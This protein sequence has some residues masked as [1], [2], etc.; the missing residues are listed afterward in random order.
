ML[1]LDTK[2]MS[3]VI[4][5]VEPSVISFPTTSP[6]E[7]DRMSGQTVSDENKLDKLSNTKRQSN[8]CTLWKARNKTSTETAIKVF[9]FIPQI[10]EKYNVKLLEYES[11]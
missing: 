11:V 4:W 9:R 10:I 1:E 7:T 3:Q 8:S 2:P 5:R 6:F